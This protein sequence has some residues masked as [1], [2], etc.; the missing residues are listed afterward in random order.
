MLSPIYIV[1]KPQ[2]KR[3]LAAGAATLLDHDISI[4]D[5]NSQDAFS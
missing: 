3:G 4:V 1:L 2:D 5:G